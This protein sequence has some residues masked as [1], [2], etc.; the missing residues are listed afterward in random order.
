MSALNKVQL[1]GN[2]GATPES[3]FTPTGKRV[4]RFSVGVN[5]RWKGEDGQEH[6]VCDWF[7]V[8]CWAGLA[9]VVSTYL[10]KGRLVYVEG[11]LQTDA[12]GEGEA[13]KY[14][15]KVVAQNVQ[16]LDKA[17]QIPVEEEEYPF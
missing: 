1:I 5:R 8:E 6:K 17:P 12:V 9:E 4:A 16:F 14:Y 15:T 10:D 7:Q 13:R 11:R 3:R 2:L